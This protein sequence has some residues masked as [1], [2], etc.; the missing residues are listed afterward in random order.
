MPVIE[1]NPALILRDSDEAQKGSRKS[2]ECIPEVLEV[3]QIY[4]FLKKEQRIYWLD[5]EVPL[6]MKSQDGM[7]SR[8]LASIQ[9]I[10]ST[11][12]VDNGRIYTRGL[13]KVTEIFQDQ[14]IH[15]EGLAKVGTN[16][17]WKS[18]LKNIIG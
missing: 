7:L 14:D 10:E 5:G 11:H 9:I 8:P 13:F 4:S 3:G 15:F 16:S 2:E 1:V 12:F 18:K 17:S 6:I